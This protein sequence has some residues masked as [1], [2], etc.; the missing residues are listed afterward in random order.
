MP[1]MRDIFALMEKY[2]HEQVVFCRH[3]GTGLKAIIGIHDTTMGP[4][5]GGCRM[6]PYESTDEALEDVLRLSRGMTFKC[7]VADVDFGGGK[8]VIIGDPVSDKSPEMFRAIGRFVGGLGGRFFTGTDMGTMPEDF[9][10]AK[11]ES[12]HFVGL[13][14]EH[15]GSG[16]TSIPTALGVLQGM[17]ATAKFLWGTESLEGRVVSIQGV[18]KVGGRLLDLL[19]EEGARAVIADINEERVHQLKEK[20]GDR[21]ELSTVTDIHRVE[22]DIFSPCAR[23]GVVN[24]T[25]IDELRCQAIVGSANNQLQE[26]R[27]GDELHERGILYAPDYLVNAGGLIQVADELEGYNEER[28]LAKTRAIYEMLLQIYER[29]RQENIGTHRAADRL[30]L[31]RLEKVADIRRIMLGWNGR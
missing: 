28:V 12:N 11:R 21:V 1:V 25:S 3:E 14:K 13:P 20:Y 27:H 23:G 10:H 8:M 6:I 5:L 17:R 22:V 9:V 15:G 19:M 29:S 16:D 18:G 30:V 2:G 7:G 4:A 26:D 31:E 24:D